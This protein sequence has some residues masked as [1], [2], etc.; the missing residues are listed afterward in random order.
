MKTDQSNFTGDIGWHVCQNKKR[1]SLRN[2]GEDFWRKLFE[3]PVKKNRKSI[4]IWTRFVSFCVAFRLL[5]WNAMVPA[6]EKIQCY[7]YHLHGKKWLR[8]K[9]TSLKDKCCRINVKTDYFVIFTVF[10]STTKTMSLW[11][12][13]QICYPCIVSGHLTQ[14]W[15]CTKTT[16]SWFISLF[17]YPWTFLTDITVKTPEKYQ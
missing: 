5:W 4:N 16:N 17:T 14:L 1:W 8:K 13:F 10:V 11:Q 15:L 3:P 7:W 9:T 6:E 2:L 12:V